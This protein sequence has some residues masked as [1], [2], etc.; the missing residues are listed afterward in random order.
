MEDGPVLISLEGNI[1]SGKSTLLEYLRNAYSGCESIVFLPEPVP[2][3]DTIQDESGMGIL[4][5]Y[6]G[7]QN[8]YAFAFQMMAYISRLGLL[9]EALRREP[10][11]SFIITERCLH[12]DKEVFARMLYDEGKLE[13][14]EHTI[15]LRWFDEFLLEVPPS[16]H[17]YVRTTP[18][19]C[20]ERVRRRG[21]DAEKGLDGDAWANYL[22]TCHEYHESWLTGGEA[23]SL[24][25][26]GNRDSRGSPAL[27]KSWT[28]L[29]CEH[30]GLPAPAGASG[31][32][33]KTWYTLQFD[34]ASR[35]N[36]G[37]CGAGFALFEERGALRRIAPVLVGAY[38]LDHGTNN[39][40]E[41]KALQIG[42]RRTI[43]WAGP[44]GNMR[45]IAVEGDSQLVI[46]QISGEYETRSPTLQPLCKACRHLLAKLPGYSLKHIPR[47]QN[48]AADQLANEGL[49]SRVHGGD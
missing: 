22:A 18:E 8:K 35:G 20:E 5:K 4:Q 45:S 6:Y 41:Y 37:P 7:D 47:A 46:K 17:I 32:P 33:A 3:W 27:H 49:D 34:G 42:L 30:T 44:Q 21:R 26:E 2:L 9:R 15:Y 13:L 40:A 29:I 1:G 39:W 28:R 36:P 48:T 14:V 19:V 43:E 12:T 11:P 23:P 38:Y 24:V 16:K 10:K 31:A 25:L